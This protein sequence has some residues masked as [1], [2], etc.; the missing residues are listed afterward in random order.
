MNAARVDRVPRDRTRDTDQTVRRRVDLKK[1]FADELPTRPATVEIR[2]LTQALVP[3]DA[4]PVLAVARSD[5]PW[6][7][8]GELA[9]QLL[10]RVDGSSSTM[11][12][13]T[14]TSATP[15]DGARELA[16]LVERG[17]LRLHLSTLDDEPPFVVEAAA[18]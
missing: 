8:L 2:A 15:S 4:V 7:E 14:G 9:A 3:L 1:A 5:V 16:A 12:I 17:L 11:S 10:R 18:G 13:V 6:H